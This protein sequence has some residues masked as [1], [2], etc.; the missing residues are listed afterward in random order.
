MAN[1]WKGNFV[2]ATAAT[3][4]GTIYTGVANGSWG[5]NSQLQQ[6]QAGLW[7]GAVGAP[8]VP[9]I[10][11]A[12]GGSTLATVSFT[13]S[14]VTGGGS[15]TY[16]A[17]STPS[18]I[19]AT[20]ATSP[21]TVTG[22]TNGTAYTFT[23]RANNSLG[24]SSAESAASN[25]VTPIGGFVA[26]VGSTSPYVTA[27]G[28]G[29]GV[30]F[31]SKFTNPS[32]AAGTSSTGVSI[33]PSNSAIIVGSGGSPTVNAYAWSNGFGSKYTIPATVP[34]SS[35]SCSFNTA[36]TVAAFLYNVTS[37]PVIA[38]AWSDGSGFGTKYAN[39]ATTT[40][41]SQRNLQF[42]STSTLVTTSCG[43]SGGPWEPNVY[44][45]SDV[46]GFGSKFTSP[47]TTNASFTGGSRFNSDSSAIVFVTSTTPFIHAY[48]F[49]GSGY[50]TKFSDPATLSANGSDIVFNSTSTAIVTSNAA[51]PGTNAW[52]W[53]SSGF[54]TKYSAPSTTIGSTTAV[55]FNT[56]NNSLVFSQGS[57]PWLGAYAWSNGY[58]TKYADTSTLH[59]SSLSN[60]AFSN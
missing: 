54:G 45:W 23:V 53:S 27:Y 12:N 59:G 1:R 31:G 60:V 30:G 18:G 16:T 39:P 2:V 8:S 57:T 24:Y 40:S 56:A 58:G 34:T 52:A 5:L 37:F 3:S 50:G 33:N 4:S 19:T 7:A 43:S 35:G 28:W 48:A 20:S 14:S 26:A 55:K 10:G 41:G 11:T 51:P 44:I 47:F 9:T 46:S 25:S 15:L 17:T 32:T 49:S 21:I 22:L 13:G 6:K 42:N 38:Y 36:G 29:D